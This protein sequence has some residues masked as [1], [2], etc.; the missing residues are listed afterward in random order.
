MEWGALSRDVQDKLFVF[1]SR[2]ENNNDPALRGDRELLCG[3]WKALRGLCRA[4]F[5][6]ECRPRG[7]TACVET[8]VLLLTGCISTGKCLP[9]YAE[10]PHLSKKENKRAYLTGLAREA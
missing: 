6:L 4:T 5:P 1:E 9:S 3:F 7:Q 2:I 8:M 10:K